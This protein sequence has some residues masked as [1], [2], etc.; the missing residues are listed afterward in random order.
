MVNEREGAGFEVM[1][2]IGRK[3]RPEKSEIRL[4]RARASRRGQR[5][6]RTM[7]DRTCETCRW[8]VR[9]PAGYHTPLIC[10]AHPPAVVLL[11][12]VEG[13]LTGDRITAAWPPVEAEDGCGEHQP[14][15]AEGTP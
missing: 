10:T 9:A 7:A 14:R 3:G 11:P 5:R 1:L 4:S 6:E 13:H 8:A 15:R 12:T 2:G